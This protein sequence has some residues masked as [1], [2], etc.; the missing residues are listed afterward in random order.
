MRVGGQDD[1][2]GLISPPQDRVARRL[3]PKVHE[4][5]ID[6]VHRRPAAHELIR[7]QLQLARVGD[8]GLQAGAS[9]KRLREPEFRVQGLRRWVVV[10]DG[11]AASRRGRGGVTP[12]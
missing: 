9:E 8:H 11:D 12:V 2:A 5:V 6:Q 3:R 7:F 4:A 1:P 10:D